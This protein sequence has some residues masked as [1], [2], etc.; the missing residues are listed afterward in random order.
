MHGAFL[1][2]DSGGIPNHNAS[3]GD[4]KRKFPKDFAGRSLRVTEPAI[5]LTL[6]CRRRA[7]SL[8]D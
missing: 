8:E 6:G 5:F 3:R 2:F 1:D 4:C 7:A